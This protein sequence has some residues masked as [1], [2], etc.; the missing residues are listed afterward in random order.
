MVSTYQYV[1]DSAEYDNASVDDNVPVHGHRCN[2][3][4]LR[5]EREEP[6]DEEKAQ[7]DA[8]DV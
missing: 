3:S 7:G 2:Y 6:D 4:S 8:V 5:P 1:V